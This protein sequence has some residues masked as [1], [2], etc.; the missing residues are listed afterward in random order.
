MKIRNGFVSNSSSS[1]FLVAFDKK[2]KNVLELHKAMFGTKST[3]VQMFDYSS[4]SS[5][6][7]AKTV[8]NSLEEQKPLTEKEIREEAGSGYFEGY[9]ETDYTQDTE[10]HRIER[11]AVRA[12]FK[13]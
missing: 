1:S 6:E 8:W 5:L 12:L 13:Y 9:P 2:P 11:E 7:V 3:T 4:Y 10:S